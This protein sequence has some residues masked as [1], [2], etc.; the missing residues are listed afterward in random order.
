MTDSARAN[1]RARVPHITYPD[2]PVSDR[3]EEISR[4][5]ERHQVVIVS[6]ETGSGKTT[7]LPKICLEMGRGDGKLIGHTQPRR[8]AARSVAE[9]ISE[10][11][12]VDLGGLV[13]YQVRF[14]DEVSKDTRI[15]LMTDGILLAE[16]PG[17][18]MLSRYDT[19]IID[20]AHE[21][22]LNIDFLL[23]YLARLLPQRP[24]LKVIITSA[25][26]DSERFA[27]H[28]GPLQAVPEEA[29]PI[30]AVSGRTYPVEIR[31]RDEEELEELDQVELICDAV[32]ELSDEGP[33]DILVFLSGEGEIRD[34]EKA[35][36]DHLP[37]YAKPGEGRPGRTEVLPLYARL[38][39]GEQHRIF[40]R[41]DWRRIVLA[42]NIAETSLTVPGIRYVIDPGT[43]RIARF[44]PKSKVQRLPIEPISQASANQRSGRCGRVADGI[45]IRLYT[46]EDFE[47]RPEFTEPEIQRTSLSS[48]ILQMAALGLGE[49][50]DFPFVD[51][52]QRRAVRAGVQQ[53]EEI[54]ALRRGRLT[55]LG[56]KIA[57]LPIDPRLARM[58]LE[59]QRNGVISEV[60]VIV[61]ALSVQDVRERPAEKRG[62]ADTYHARFI[63]PRSDFIAYLNLWRYLNL[64]SRELSGSAMRRTCRAEY[65][66]YLRFREWRDVVTQLR[67]LT[68][69]LG[70]RRLGLPTKRMLA[71]A[72]DP[73]SAARAFDRSK[74]DDIHRS[75]LPGMLSQ[76]GSWDMRRKDYE[77]ARGSRFV[78]WPGSGL[79]NKHPD[80]VMAAELVE[81]S[82]LFAR[83]VAQIRPEWIEE[84]A[85]HL[86]T[87]QHSEPYWSSKHG[88]AMVHEKVMLYGLT[89]IADRPV[90]LTKV[91]TADAHALAREILIRHGLVAQDWR[92]HY[93]F[94]TANTEALNEAREV[95]SRR[96][97]RGLVADEAALEGFF[98]ERIPAEVV[99]GG[100]FAAWYKRHPEVSLVYPRSLLLGSEEVAEEDYP[101][102]W[103]QGEIELP[104][105]YDFSPGQ[106]T[107]GLT[108]EIPVAVLPQLTDA[109]FDWLVPG[110]A[111]ELAEATIRSLPKRLRRELVPAPDV[112][113]QIAAI[114]P[115]WE[116]V[117]HGSGPSYHEAFAAAAAHLRGVDIDEWG[118]LP[119]HLR[120]T[121]RVVSRRGA[122]LAEGTSIADLKAQLAPRTQEAVSRAVRK[123]VNLATKV[124]AEGFGSG[125][126]LTVE[127][128][129]VKG[130]PALVA[131]PDKVE[132]KV[133]DN[134]A[135]QV[136]E[137]RKGVLTMLAE[138]LALPTAR[139]TSRW[140]AAMS[141]TMA[142]SPYDSTDDLVSDLTFAA[143]RNLAGDVSSVRTE[144]A[145]DALVTKLRDRVEDEIF[146]IAQ[147]VSRILEA[148][149][150]TRAAIDSASPALA[151]QKAEVAEVFHHL[152][153]P[154]FI[155]A[156][157]D[158]W[159]NRLPTYL[160]AGTVRLETC[161][162]NLDLDD[163]RADTVAEA[164]ELIEAADPAT[165]EEAAKV[166]RAKWM[167]EELRVSL[168]AQK[169]GTAV[170]VSLPRIAKLLP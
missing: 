3:R 153:R 27:N 47:S 117:A 166:E 36:A 138:K 90:P 96:R 34:T 113:A 122:I 63:D 86:L 163:E 16:I 52:P 148:A 84:A 130:Y 56:R 159:L 83:T 51:P 19:I 10:E 134:P 165:G 60:L 87:Y 53:L 104:I 162:A 35:L 116:E 151:G 43:A 9:R 129:G 169:L 80:W 112:A 150:T 17:D 76:L 97:T 37:D 126:P 147:I 29:A 146:R 25:T 98:D 74:I 139:V 75:L 44:S 72:G 143:V 8:I 167:L 21:R 158:E 26:I 164:A 108:I 109:G 41:H 93:D 142:A 2:L 14:T 5:I 38:S 68:R 78:I 33:G 136:R 49:V 168:F 110:M 111:G 140:P 141:L 118:T 77:G 11:M 22:S 145:F 50:E 4:A 30:I 54:G 133:L 152:I 61:A 106:R 161:A 115:D 40:A 15:K 81:T 99:T 92:E 1:R 137:H 160:A 59:G 144:E 107:D 65:L 42:T 119:D 13:G 7:Q 32:D 88:A 23:G 20:E 70:A 31:Y 64:Q 73:A 67:Q 58:L 135:E 28:F 120:I 121:F 91:G 82:R 156:T 131:G 79:S 95:E 125:L 103:V 127:A 62:E 6:G 155:G 154:G 101:T 124:P 85:G 89:I 114:L 100:H 45:A 94:M 123:A 55:K 170:K 46:E 66:N 39:A 71:E 149:R 105:S 69:S 157:P 132:V 48:V 12:N 128:G 24:D 57:R 102:T 18:P